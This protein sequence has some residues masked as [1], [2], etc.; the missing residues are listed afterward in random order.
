MIT[1]TTKVNQLGKLIFNWLCSYLHIPL[2]SVWPVCKRKMIG[3]TTPLT[4]T[5]ICSVSANSGNCGGK[6]RKGVANFANTKN[7]LYTYYNQKN[8]CIL[9]CCAK[10][11]K[12]IYYSYYDSGPS[13]SANCRVPPFQSI[14][15]KWASASRKGWGWFPHWS[16]NI[17]I[18]SW[19]KWGHLECVDSCPVIKEGVALS[20]FLCRANH[21][22]LTVLCNL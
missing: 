21:A 6:P 13:I 17:R 4:C 15:G 20:C 10:I 1:S 5:H 9:I 8:A 3:A 19:S 18:V 12:G 7:N 14:R 16:R 2:P 11:E 22:N